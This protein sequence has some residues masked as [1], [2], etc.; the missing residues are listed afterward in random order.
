[1]PLVTFILALIFLK[2]KVDLISILSC[3]LCVVG[4]AIIVGGA[5][6][7]TDKFGIFLA[8]S[9]TFFMASLPPNPHPIEIFRCALGYLE[10]PVSLAFRG[11]LRD[12]SIGERDMIVNPSPKPPSQL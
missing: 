10:K 7:F 3:V 9:M 2:T 8:F 6:N 4:A 1:M 11:T 5:Q 12:L